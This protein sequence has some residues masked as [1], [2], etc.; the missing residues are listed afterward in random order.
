[1]LLL[2]GAGAAALGTAAVVGI[3]RIDLP[4]EAVRAIA[5]ALPAAVLVLGVV[6]L[7]LGALLGRVAHHEAQDR[8]S[9]GARTAAPPALGSA[10]LHVPAGPARDRDPASPAPARR[11]T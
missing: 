10:P 9:V 11:V 4:P 3:D 6:L 8:G 7:F 2:L 1:M 5:V